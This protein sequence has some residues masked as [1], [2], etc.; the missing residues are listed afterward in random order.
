MGEFKNKPQEAQWSNLSEETF[1]N[2]LLEADVLVSES[3]LQTPGYE[4][5]VSENERQ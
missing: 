1:K 2:I 5:C 3:V 4:I